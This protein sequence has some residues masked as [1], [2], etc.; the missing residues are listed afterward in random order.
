MLEGTEGKVYHF[1]RTPEMEELRSQ[2]ELQTNSFIRLRKFSTVRGGPGH[3][4]F[5]SRL[6]QQGPPSRDGTGN[7][8]T[9]GLP[10]GWRLEWMART[11]SES[12]G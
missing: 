11:L 8:S 10:S 7:N 6:A 1:Y 2:R 3:W 5:G 9:R 4:L 12:P